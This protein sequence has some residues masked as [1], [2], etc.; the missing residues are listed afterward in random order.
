[1]ISDA[2]FTLLFCLYWISLISH[3]D[4]TRLAIVKTKLIVDVFFSLLILE[5]TLILHTVKKRVTI[6]LRWEILLRRMWPKWLCN[7][8]GNL[9]IFFVSFIH[10]V[11]I[12][13]WWIWC[14][15]QVELVKSTKQQ[16]SSAH[17]LEVFR[18]SL[19]QYVIV[20]TFFWL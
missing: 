13:L 2:N 7:W 1:M 19:S 4:F 8:S 18:G 12:T 9:L 20:Y 14:S 16:F 5:K 3:P 11:K 6:A 15:L 17:I 10:S